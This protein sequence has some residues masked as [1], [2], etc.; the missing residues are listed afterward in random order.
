M[1]LTQ[2]RL[3]YEIMKHFVEHAKAP[4]I[5][6]LC[7]ISEKSRAC[8]VVALKELQQDH[9]V[10]L[11]PVSN[12]VWVM[13]P[14]SSAPTNF[15]IQSG[16]MGW[17]GN[18]AWCALGAAA[19]LDR[20]LTITTTL[21]SESKQV[22]VEIINGSIANKHLYVHFPIP[23]EKAWDN[24]I[25]TCSTMLM[26]ESES[27]IDVWCERHNMCKGDVQPIEH[28]WEFSK[29]WYGHHLSPDWVKWTVQEAAE[30]FERFGLTH[31][32]W[33]LPVEK[34]RF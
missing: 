23:M 27:D 1:A 20:D 28:I 2:S 17:W 29:V 32:I 8:I 22:V 34:G 31:S 6:E 5:D 12:E 11:H 26:F 33:K 10:V 16:D 9:G 25:Y 24:V 19:L 18:C 21:G 14:F 7:V 30:I 13:H 3:H 4:S 15:W